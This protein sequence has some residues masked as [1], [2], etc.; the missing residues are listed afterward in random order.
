MAERAI[1]PKAYLRYS[2][3]WQATIRMDP[4]AADRQLKANV[5]FNLISTSNPISAP[6][7]GP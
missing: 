4:S 7:L 2:D 3:A 6:S 5:A 1:A